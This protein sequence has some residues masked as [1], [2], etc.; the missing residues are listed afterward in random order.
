M[1]FRVSTTFAPQRRQRRRTRR[2]SETLIAYGALPDAEQIIHC[3]A[4]VFLDHQGGFHNTEERWCL[5]IEGPGGAR[6]VL[7]QE[8]QRD[9]R[10]PTLGKELEALGRCAPP[11][12]VDASPPGH[13]SDMMAGAVWLVG[14][15]VLAAC[16]R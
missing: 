8:K 14:I 1:L 16:L 9:R 2:A 15:L 3:R 5:E 13:L 7:V 11:R 6:V 10:L 12:F 4:T